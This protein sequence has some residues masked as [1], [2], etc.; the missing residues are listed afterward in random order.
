V[1]EWYGIE[2]PKLFRE[3]KQPLMIVSGLAVITVIIS[4]MWV[5]LNVPNYVDLTPQLKDEIRTQLSENI[6]RISS[7]GE[8]LP[9]HL[10]F[11]NNA[12]V[13]VISLLLGLV[14]FGTLGMTI[15]LG[16]MGLIGG[17]LG[18]ANLVGYSPLL[19][20]AAGIL[21]HGIF[22]L[23]AIFLATAAMLKVGAQLV[24]PQPEKSLGETFLLSLADWSRVFVGLVLPLLAIASVIE[25]YVTP[26]LIQ[27]A[28]PYL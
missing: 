20:F 23:T 11:F 25:I 5:V 21:P 3:L 6:T 10:V 2:I 1:R 8:E 15:F 22:E 7:L 17:V 18:A 28:F 12:R 13:T 16:N 27:L 4:Y 24:T 14:S 9:A 26:A 19:T